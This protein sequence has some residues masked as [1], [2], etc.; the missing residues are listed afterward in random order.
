MSKKKNDDSTVNSQANADQEVDSG[1][2]MPDDFQLVTPMEGTQRWWKQEVGGVV[3][4]RLLGRFPRR[5]GDGAYYQIRIEK[6]SKGELP[7]VHA[8][9]G[10]G[11]NAKTEIVEVGEVINMDERSSIANLAP[12]AMSD[13]VFNVL[14]HCLEKV[15]IS[16]GRTYW[17]MTAGTKQ[18]KAPTSPL[19]PI[20][21]N[22]TDDT[23]ATY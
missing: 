3:F 14:I 6:Y 23:G 4:G 18:L 8:I 15:K 16:G 22:R 1:F 7:P 2:Q 21:A 17:R 5:D 9:S 10:K 12:Q 11:D 13:G 20:K 19:A